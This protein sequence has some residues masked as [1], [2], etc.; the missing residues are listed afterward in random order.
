MVEI[1]TQDDNVFTKDS[2][3]INHFFAIE[4][5]M[6]QVIS[7]EMINLFASIIEFNDLLVSQFIVTEW[8]TSHY[9]KLKHCSTKESTMYLHLK[10]MSSFISG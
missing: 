1:R 10:S 5:S 2:K 6:S 4:K 3:P 7:E 9:Q 8:S